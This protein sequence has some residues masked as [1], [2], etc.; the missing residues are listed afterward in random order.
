M[1]RLIQWRALCIARYGTQPHLLGEML[2]AATARRSCM[3]R[4]AARPRYHRLIAASAVLFR[5][6]DQRAAIHPRGP[7]A[8][9]ALTT[10]AR[11]PQYPDWP[12]AAESGL[13]GFVATYWNGVLAPAGTPAS[14]IARL[15]APSTRACARK[16]CGPPC[17]SSVPI[18][19]SCRPRVLRF[20]VGG[21]RNWSDVARPLRSSG[22]TQGTRSPC[23]PRS[24]KGIETRAK[25]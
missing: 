19:K 15:N 13:N 7:A 11:D 20:H 2:K 4:I 18:P 16:R 8:A 17:A 9:L 25:G 5:Q 23:G 1:P 6:R 21:Q 10:E 14:V 22:V 24:Q 3:F 12:T